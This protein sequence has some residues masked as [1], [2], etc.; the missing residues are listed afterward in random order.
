MNQSIKFY[1]QFVNHYIFVTLRRRSIGPFRGARA[2]PERRHHSA[3]MLSPRR[4][5]AAAMIDLTMLW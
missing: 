2:P 5:A 4:V 3:A 1:S